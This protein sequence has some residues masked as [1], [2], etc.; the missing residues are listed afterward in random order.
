MLHGSLFDIR[1]T[2][3]YCNYSAKNDF[4][5]PIVPALA[6]PKKGPQPAPSTEDKTGEKATESLYGAMGLNKSSKASQSEEVDISDENVPIPELS[7][8]DL[9]RCPECKKGLLR[10]GVVWFGEP[11]PQDTITAVDDWIMESRIDLILV[12]GTSSKVYPA[13]GYVEEA[14]VKGARV[15]VINMDRA[16]VPGRRH[17]LMKIDWFFQGDAGE[18]VP[19]ILKSIVGEI[20]P[21][22]EN[23]KM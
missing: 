11:L 3:Y 15:A 23:S 10:P 18:I 16:D 2:S 8:K 13:A 19:E 12:I 9:P 14:R 5:D 17:G 22:S 20:K 7:I 1:C 21:F 6:I 4:T